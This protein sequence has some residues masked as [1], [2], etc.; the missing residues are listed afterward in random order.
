MPKYKVG[1]WEEQSGYIYIDAEDE[2]Q[3]E[4]IVDE[5]LAEYGVE[6]LTLPE[7]AKYNYSN[8]H[9]SVE[10]IQQPE[11]VETDLPS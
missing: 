4:E 1:V 3:A 11:E 10:I 5:I 9:R 6:G 7:N 2:A 8:E